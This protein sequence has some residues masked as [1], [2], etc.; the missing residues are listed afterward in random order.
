MKWPHFTTPAG[1]M[2]P[3]NPDHVETVR[4]ALPG[5]YAATG[6]TVIVMAN[7]YQVVRESRAEVEKK[8]GIGG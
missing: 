3:I 8:L 7:G 4:D 5:E 2:V 1:K 6:R